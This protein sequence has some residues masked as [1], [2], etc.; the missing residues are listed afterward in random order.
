[1][2][3]KLVYKDFSEMGAII[4]KNCAG[5]LMLKACEGAK[6]PW[7]LAPHELNQLA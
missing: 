1:M 3:T 5:M 4:L 6:V 2:S 7:G